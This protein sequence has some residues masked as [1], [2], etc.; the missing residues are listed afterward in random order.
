MSS[1]A[2]ELR[3]TAS[4]TASVGSITADATRP[5]RGK[6]HDLVV[7]SEATPADNAFL[8]RVRR[9]TAAGT[10]T[11]VTPVALDPADAATETDAGENHTVEPTYTANSELLLIPLNQKATFRW[12]AAPGKE[13]VWPATASNGIGVE[14]PTASAVTVAAMAYFEEQ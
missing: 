10:S 13:L 6:L 3:R 14:T 1:F 2:V 9:C 11:A 7:G 4:T 12:A 5:R 8:W